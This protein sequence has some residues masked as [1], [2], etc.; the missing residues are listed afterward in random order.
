[1]EMGLDSFL[2]IYESGGEGKSVQ[3]SLRPG[4]SKMV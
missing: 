2:R 4:K 1:M 3:L